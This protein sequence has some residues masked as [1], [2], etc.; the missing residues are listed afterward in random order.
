MV[1]YLLFSVILSAVCADTFSQH[2]LLMLQKKNKNK[3]VYYQS[4]DV[5]SFKVIG[6]SKK[7]TSEIVQIKDS[8]IVL[9]GYEVSVNKIFCLYVDEKTR[10]WLRYKIAQL[11][12]IVGGGYLL[13]E[14][15]NTGEL[16][17]ETL[18]ISG[19]VIGV[20][21]IAKLFISN[22]IK[23]KGRTKLRILEL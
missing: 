20:G 11:S 4:G 3:N 9:K 16:N 14:V 17:K 22:K 1:N 19:S 6:D 2:H 21:L 18:I 10:W 15:I 23:I 5:I 7:R 8:V 13:L 12:F